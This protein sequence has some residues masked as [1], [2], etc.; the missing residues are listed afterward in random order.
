MTF[1]KKALFSV[2]LFIGAIVAGFIFLLR[3]CLSKY[4]ERSALPGILYFEKADQGVIF[5]IVKFEKATSYS[6]K[7]GMISK[8]VSTNYFIQT[9]DAAAGKKIADKK[10]MHHSDIKNHPVETLGSSNNMA[11]IFMNELMAFDPFTLEQKAGLSMFE[12]KNPSLKG[13]FPNERR[14]YSFDLP[15]QKIFFT[16]KDG[17]TWRLD[18]KTLVASPDEYVPGES[19]AEK[20]VERLEK[21]IAFNRVQQDSMF[22]QKIRRPSRLLAA[23]EIN[24]NEYNRINQGFNEERNR[25]YK[26]RD[27]LQHLKSKVEKEEDRD[28]D[29]RR[30][31]ASLQDRSTIHFSQVKVNA[32]TTNSHWYGLYSS[33]EMN[34][35]YNRFQYQSQY[36]ETARRQLYTTTYGP[37]RNEDIIIA[38]DHATL[39]NASSY[40]LDGGFLLN[41]QTGRPIQLAGPS[42]LIVHKDQVG[43]DGKIQVS[44]INADGTINWTF[45]SQLKEWSNYIYT[46][47]WLIIIGTNNKELSSSDCNLLWCVDIATG[48]ASGYDYFTNVEM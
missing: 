44:Y 11:W 5:S 10:I 25:L 45:D 39:Q 22:E 2:F 33:K 40:F 38:T 34:K 15:S 19:V 7:G 20:E 13:K 46:G 31:I 28:E 16:A 27:S 29:I 4:D 6:Q 37:D 24:R 30:K 41:K 1:A 36:D 48:K 26:E 12:Q 32:D 9:N 47:K 23:G 42:F 17:S 43:N 21:L 35:L 8:S 14:Y 18:T 3:G